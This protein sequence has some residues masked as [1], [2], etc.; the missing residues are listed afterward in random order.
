VRISFKIKIFLLAVIAAVLPTTVMLWKTTQMKEILAENGDTEFNALSLE[1][2]AQT[3]KNLYA[4]CETANESVQQ[5][6]LFDLNVARRIFRQEGKV[7][8]AATET[9]SWDS[10]NPSDKSIKTA[11]LPRFIMGTTAIEPNSDPK[12]K[13]SV[14]D[15]VS[16]LV[17]GYCGIFQRMNEAGDM[18]MISTNAE[19]ADRKREVGAVIPVLNQDGSS[20]SIISTILGGHAYKGLV[21]IASAACIAAYE[22]VRD[23]DGQIVGMLFVGEKIDAGSSIRKTVLKTKLGK[24]GYAGVVG[25]KG[26]QRGRY[27]ISKNGERDGESIWET[28]DSTGRY[29]I[30]ELVNKPM[31]LSAGEIDIERYLWKNPGESTAR[32]KKSVSIY[33]EPWDWLIFAGA[34]EDEFSPAKDHME[35]VMSNQYQKLIYM[36]VFILFSAVIF[37]SFLCIT[38]SRPLHLLI[39]LAQTI[40]GGKVAEAKAELTRLGYTGSNEKDQESQSFGGDEI[41]Q[42]LRAFQGMVYNLDSLIGQVHRSGIQV[43]A[44]TTEI[45][46]S[47][48]HLEATVA[49]Q[50]AAI[51]EVTT[52]TKEISGTAA[53]LAQAMD[54]VGKT[55]EDTG[56]MTEAGQSNLMK[57]GKALRELEKATGL[58]SGKLAVIN[59]KTGKISG[60]VST[61]NKISDQTNLLSLNAAIEAEKAGEYGRGFSVVAREISRLADQT[62][63]ATQDIE[64]MVKEMQSSVSTGVM[65]MDKFTIEVRECVS[66]VGSISEQLGKIIIDQMGSLGPQFESVH[67]GTQVQADGA[68]QISEAMSQLSVTADHNKEALLEFKRVTE[69]LNEAVQGLQKEVS[70]FKV[71]N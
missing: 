8:L 70:H 60:V 46:A 20:N 9:V 6:I 18:L 66:E 47:A 28:Q 36:G 64:H 26:N 11:N 49:E 10:M 5:R 15:D 56:I 53:N 48:R 32:A 16:K 30:Q 25:G 69:H 63:V 24:T 35:K 43:S 3:T 2:I 68:Q 1:L 31:T 57:M 4:I 14:V 21:T 59:D 65:G 22:P 61:I 13:A 42:L 39:Q 58:I 12:I 7:R 34:Y 17:G 33:F 29:I 19:T 55:V 45:S 27:I 41:D 67:M 40:S 51:R 71:S 38:L 23:N 50:A 37:A 52:T 44:S 54:K 62:A